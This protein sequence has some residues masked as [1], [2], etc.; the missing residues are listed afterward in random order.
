MDNKFYVPQEMAKRLKEA[1]YPVARK[2]DKE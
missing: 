1:G 2:E